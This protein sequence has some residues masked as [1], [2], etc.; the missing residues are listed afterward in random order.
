[1][2]VAALACA[3]A[4]AC[5]C[6]GKGSPCEA[7]GGA[8]A[9]FV[10]TVTSVEEGSRKQKPDGGLDFKPRLVRFAVEQ[11]FLGGAG[12][13]A[14]VATG[15]GGLDCGY[16]F[17]KG[18]T[19]LVYAYKTGEKDEP[20]YTSTCSHTTPVDKADED[21]AYLR[22]MG[23]PDAGFTVFAKVFR[24]LSYPGPDQMRA[25]VPME[26]SALS[27]EGSGR[28][29]EARA[30]ARGLYKFTGLLPGDYRLK[31]NLPDELRVYMPEREV[32]AGRRGCASE[33]FYVTDNGRVSGRITGPDGQPVAGIIV[34]IVDATGRDL[35][36]SGDGVYAKTDEDGRYHFAGIPAGEYMLGV[37]V[38][39][40]PRV[41]HPAEQSK[42]KVCN[43]CV[44]LIGAYVANELTSA[45][46]RLFYPGVPLISKGAHLYLTPGQVLSDVDWT[47]PPRRG[48]AEVRGRVVWED[49][50]PSPGADVLYR[51]ATYEDPG[52]WDYTVRADE[53][54]E[55][56]FKAYRG[57]RYVV[58]ASS[59]EPGPPNWRVPTTVTVTNPTETITVVIKKRKKL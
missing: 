49:G 16:P 5:G 26:G 4:S 31:L 54:G 23:G 2:L 11:T 32:K 18:A 3:R 55:F 58:N 28:S 6:T 51:D 15:L 9:V 37:N 20:L 35:E 56:P 45:Y 30:D 36:M 52:Y 7:F 17:A 46:P 8:S 59:N 29:R 33:V 38:R 21:L 47:L 48:E 57:G 50:T 43:N 1:M 42:E 39:G 10:G 13:E 27:L 19:Y 40:T 25:A 12:A 41:T 53:R 14:E 34:V 22:G 44:R 24:R